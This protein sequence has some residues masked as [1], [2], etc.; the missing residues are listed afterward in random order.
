MRARRVLEVGVFLGYTTMTLAKNLPE[1]GKVFGLELSSERAQV[2][3]KHIAAANL[4][5]KVKIITGPALNSMQRLAE[6]E[7]G[8]FDFVFIDAD[9]RNY[10]SY[11]EYALDLLRK[12]GVLAVDNV[13]WHGKVVDENIND[14]STSAIRDLNKMIKEDERVIVSVLPLSDGLTLCTKL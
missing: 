13:L 2:A 9:K 11:Y 4:S 3:E 1:G 8:T 12:G 10:I 14:A 7:S 5:D 6:L